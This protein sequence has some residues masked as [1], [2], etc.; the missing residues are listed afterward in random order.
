[1]K[2]EKSMGDLAETPVTGSTTIAGCRVPHPS[3]FLRRVGA[4]GLVKPTQS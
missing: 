2:T 4:A 3:R 1:M